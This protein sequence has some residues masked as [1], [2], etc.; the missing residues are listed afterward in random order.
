MKIPGIIVA[1]A[2]AVSPVG[3]QVAPRVAASLPPAELAALEI[4]RKDVWTNWFS[5]DTAALHR[6]LGPELVA[7]GPDSRHW[8]TLG[9]SL[10]WSARFKAS[11]RTLVSVN[12][13][14]NMVHRFGDVVLMFSHYALVLDSAGTR[15]SIGGR[16]TEVFVRKNGRWVHTSWHLD[17]VGPGRNS[18]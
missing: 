14:S 10:A 11:G 4:I 9:E 5:G 8:Q 18:G 7:I 13:D 1:L 17:E 2:T 16:V 15:A 12:F 6:T 3:A